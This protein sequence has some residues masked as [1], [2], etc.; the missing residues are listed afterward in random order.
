MGCENDAKI[1]SLFK[2]KYDNYWRQSTWQH[3]DHLHNCRVK[4]TMNELGKRQY[5]KARL[6]IMWTRVS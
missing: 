4:G 5:I 6:V 2:T 3:R 1:V